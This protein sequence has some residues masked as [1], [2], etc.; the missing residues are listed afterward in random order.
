[1]AFR[2]LKEFIEVLEKEKEL[3]RVKEYV[4]PILEIAESAERK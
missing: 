3:I 4:N 1:M 2:G